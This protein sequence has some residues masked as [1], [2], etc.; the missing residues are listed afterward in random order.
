MI[1]LIAAVNNNMLLG[2]EGR[3][4][5]HIPEDL[6]FFKEKTIHKTV[7]MGRRTFD[8]IP[9]ILQDRDIYVLTSS[10][11]LSKSASNVTIIHH[12]EPLIEH[13]TSSDDELMVAGGGVVYRLM[14]P[15]ADKIYLSVIDDDQHGDVYFPS[16]ALDE[17][18]IV[19]ILEKKCFKI[20]EYRRIR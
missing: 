15:Y 6:A 19:Q 1:T 5:W 12:V 2:K 18:E 16:I 14:M 3:M 7:L 10:N 8:S 9:K 11:K 17:F 20:F 4:P 13:Y